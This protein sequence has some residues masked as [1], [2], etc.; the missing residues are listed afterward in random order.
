LLLVQSG[1]AFL[2]FAIDS[3]SPRVSV[4]MPVYNGGAVLLEAITSILTQNFGDFELIAIDDGSTDSSFDVIAGINDSRIRLFRNERNLGLVKTLNRGMKLARARYLARMDADDISLPDRLGCQLQYMLK[5]P[6]LGICGTWS[7]TIG[8]PTMSWETHFPED[9]WNIVAHMLFNTAISHPTAM[10]DLNKLQAIGLQYDEAAPHAED[11]DLWV[12]AAEHMRLGNVP[13]VLLHY[14][15]HSNQVSNYAADIQRQ[16]G[17]RV[18]RKLLARFAVPIAS[19]DLRIHAELATYAWQRDRSFYDRAEAWLRK[20]TMTAQVEATGKAA[21]R[22]ECAR[23]LLELR[24]HVFGPET[25][26]QRLK[27]AIEGWLK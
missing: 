5:R 19:C 21:I 6:E 17:D 24:R 15:V 9:H 27:C 7:K 2:T 22:K 16:T 20:L 23:R 25:G 8:H 10:L 26:W 11:Y 14:R 3:M 18:R 12:N 13:T 4:L 1:A